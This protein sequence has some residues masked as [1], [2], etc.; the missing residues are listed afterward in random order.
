[1]GPLTRLLGVRVLLDVQF[2]FPTWMIFL[3]DQ[4]YSPLE[5]AAVDA[6]FNAVV[7]LA[8]IPLGRVVDA[9]GRKRA[10]I[11]TCALTSVVFAGIG[12]APSFWVMFAV[13]ALWGVLWALASGVDT[14]YA[15][16]LADQL[17][18]R[19]SPAR[20]LGR[21]RLAGGIAGVISL[22]T[23]GLLL[24]IWAPLP[25]LVTAGLALIALPLALSIPDV[26]RSA[27]HHL[28]V[29]AHSLRDALRH[30]AV[31]SG[32]LLA[33]IILTAGVSIRIVFQPVGLG[34]GFSAFGISIAYGA[35]ALSVAAGGW[36][37]SRIAAAHRGRWVVL[38]VALMAGSYLLTALTIHLDS[39]WATM[40]VAIPAGTAAFGMGKTI[41]DIW[42][43]ESVGPR[44]RA[45]VLSIASAA[46]GLMMV[47]LRPVLLLTA[48]SVGDSLAFLLW[49]AVSVGL[50]LLCIP[51]VRAGARTA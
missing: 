19:L 12:L 33:A 32:I 27:Q 22:V 49:A 8:E 1:M 30:P 36:L 21:T 34:L 6:V 9:I 40:L 17:P 41:T 10:L 48:D 26:S 5:A 14:T 31:R 37:G 3:L 24:E 7:V 28:H 29:T 50:C 15:W 39:G 35:I 23:A 13:W 38:S 51:L 2:W 44:W 18:G 4:G 16:E 47:G 20:Y 43:I 46:N 25:Y 45:T 11:A 42:I